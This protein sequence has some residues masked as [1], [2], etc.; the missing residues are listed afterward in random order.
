MSFDFLALIIYTIC[1]SMITEYIIGQHIF[2]SF[3]IKLYK[4]SKFWHKFFFCRFC[5]IGKF[6]MIVCL[7][8]RPIIMNVKGFEI[9][10]EWFINTLVLN[11]CCIIMDSILNLSIEQIMK[12]SEKK[13]DET[14][15]KL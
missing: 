1:I 3:Q 11:F 7:F 4:K 14:M 10:L 15:E 5:F 13:F 12:R 6:A 9:L 8:S 2:D